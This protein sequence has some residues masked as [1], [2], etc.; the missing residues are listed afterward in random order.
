ML[1]YQG[2]Y[3][4]CVVFNDEIEEEAVKQIY[5]F[6]NHPAFEGLTIRIMPDV[7]AGSGAV[8]GFT[9]NVGDK[10]I[11]NVVGVD[12]CCGM[13]SYN[14][15]K[16]EVNFQGLDDFITA[17]IPSGF[18]RRSKL[19]SSPLLKMARCQE[20]H[21]EEIKST[22]IN[23]GQDV[24]Y[25]LSSIGTLGGGN[26][27]I[28]LGQ[29][30]FND[31]WLTIHSGSRNFGLKIAQY[32][33]KI[34]SQTNLFGDL[35]YLSGANTESY[36]RDT[37]AA[38]E[39]ARI[40]REVM[41][42]LIS[43][44]HFKVMP[45][46]KI[47]CVHNYI[48]PVDMMVRKGAISAKK[49]EPVII[50]WN[51]RDGLI[52]GVGKGNKEWN[53]SAPHGAGRKMGRSAAKKSILLKDFELSMKNVWSSCVNESTLDES[54]FVYKDHVDIEKYL[55]DTVEITHRVKPVYNF[56]ASEKT[57]PPQE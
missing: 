13:L 8:I 38:A 50:P 47:E 29:D 51:M 21:L 34:A 53:N 22:A 37:K 16:V 43:V 5:R 27:F 57:A 11:P 6:L 31:Y 36:L 4:S 14:L 12:I 17:N 7:H 44:N 46:K 52:I 18:S 3:G 55:G 26:H 54:P 1:Q 33:Q 32:H 25:V 10:V 24:G 23:T 45:K 2:Q 49:D 40:S 20:H 48:D 56:K 15:G 42:I 41:A 35:S 39:F 30:Q 19:A 9:S 28:E